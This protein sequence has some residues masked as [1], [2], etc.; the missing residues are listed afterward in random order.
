MYCQN[1]FNPK[2]QK[3][4]NWARP[5]SCKVASDPGEDSW[6][7]RCGGVYSSSWC[8]LSSK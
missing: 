6:S 2:I 5:K 3:V 1:P 8:P 4:K 7:R